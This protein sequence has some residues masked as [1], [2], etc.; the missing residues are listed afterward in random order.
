MTTSKGMEGTEEEDETSKYFAT[1]NTIVLSLERS[2][3]QVKKLLFCNLAEAY[4][5]CLDG[6]PSWNPMMEGKWDGKGKSISTFGKW[7]EVLPFPFLQQPP[8]SSSRELGN[9]GQGFNANLKSCQR[10]HGPIFPKHKQNKLREVA[11]N[12][13]YQCVSAAAILPLLFIHLSVANKW[14]EDIPWVC[15]AQLAHVLSLF[16]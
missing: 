12:G 16:L 4:N 5:Q 11:I 6:G 14:R 15:L 8:K 13:T 1:K 9:Q 10:Y 2:I 7:S 3:L